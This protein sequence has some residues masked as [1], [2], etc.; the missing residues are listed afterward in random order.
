MVPSV[1]VVVLV[2][3]AMMVV[4]VAVFVKSAFSTENYPPKYMY[5][6]RQTNILLKV[7]ASILKEVWMNNNNK[8]LYLHD[9]NLYSIAK[10]YNKP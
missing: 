8:N 5:F 9:R 10:A 3:V 6:W 4:A 7:K 1:V 2:V